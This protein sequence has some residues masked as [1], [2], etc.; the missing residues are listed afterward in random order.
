[1]SNLIDICASKKKGE[2]IVLVVML[3]G[4]WALVKTMIVI[5]ECIGN[6][7]GTRR[8]LI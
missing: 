7:R 5:I 1:V 6:R 4:H 3:R 2:F 8:M